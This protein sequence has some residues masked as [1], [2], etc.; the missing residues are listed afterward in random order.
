M[1]PEV[2]YVFGAGTSPEFRQQIRDAV[3]TVV[4]YSSETLGFL[5]RDFTVFAFEDAEEYIDA[6]IEWHEGLN[7]GHRDSYIEKW[8]TG[9]P[10]HGGYQHLFVCTACH[11]VSRPFHLYHEYFHVLQATL[12]KAYE[13]PSLGATTTHPSQVPR[14]GPMWL[15]EGS[16]Q[17]LAMQLTPS[18]QLSSILPPGYLAAAATE[19]VALSEMETAFGLDDAGGYH[20]GTAAAQLLADT[21]GLASL[22]RFFEEVGEGTK[23]PNAFQVVLGPSVEEFYTEFEGYRLTL[24]K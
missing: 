18:E 11:P 8:G 15:I 6:Y 2:N 13:Q 10:G 1:P 9:A 21:S 12:S 7:A 5:T 16:A 24:G 3:E 14:W 19:D 20:S 17:Y 22:I 4:D 23:W